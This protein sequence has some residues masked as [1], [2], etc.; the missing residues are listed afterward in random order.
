MISTDNEDDEQG[1]PRVGKWYQTILMANIIF[2]KYYIYTILNKLS[3]LFLSYISSFLIVTQST[4][5]R[6]T[7]NFIYNNLSY[8]HVFPSI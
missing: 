5:K 1:M 6:S 2:F 3:F 8:I 4:V 7:V